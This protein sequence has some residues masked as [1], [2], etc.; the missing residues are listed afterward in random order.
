MKRFLSIRIFGL[1]VAVIAAFF[2]I[3]TDSAHAADTIPY[4]MN[5][6]GRLTGPN[7]QIVPNGVY[8]TRFQLFDSATG[9]SAL[10]TSTRLVS[11]GTAVEVTNGQFT[12][13]LGRI[14][15]LGPSLFTTSANDLYLE[16]ELPSTSTA[17]TSIPVW[18]EGLMTPRNQVLSSAY[19]FNADKLDGL[20]GDDF[21]KIGSPPIRSRAIRHSTVLGC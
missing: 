14:V 12:A 10:W 11:A 20:D 15:T 3:F 13:Q 7:G 19:S 1:A 21:A 2:G 16:V 18:T 6:Q 9:G 8:N 17:T 4:K 5:F